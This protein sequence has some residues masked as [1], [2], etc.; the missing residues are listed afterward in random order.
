MAF[1]ALPVCLEGQV[2]TRLEHLFCDE[3]LHVHPGYVPWTASLAAY[4]EAVHDLTQSVP[5]RAPRSCRKFRKVRLAFNCCCLPCPGELLLAKGLS[6]LFFGNCAGSQGRRGLGEE[7]HLHTKCSGHDLLQ[8]RWRSRCSA[9]DRRVGFAAATAG[10]GPAAQRA[11]PRPSSRRKRMRRV[12]RYYASRGHPCF[13]CWCV[14]AM[15]NGTTASVHRC[16]I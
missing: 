1:R 13:H 14:S 11:C 15:W 6:L 12:S 16:H 10:D 5:A 8:L 2:A 3:T 7:I 4:V 9:P